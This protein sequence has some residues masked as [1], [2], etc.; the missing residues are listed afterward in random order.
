MFNVIRIM[1]KI[2]LNMRTVDSTAT[3][4]YTVGRLR[5][6]RVEEITC[7]LIERLFVSHVKTCY[8]DRSMNVIGI[9][10]LHS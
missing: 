7:W 8:R 10:L 2:I 4:K 1:Y 6:R 5:L 9:T 3:L